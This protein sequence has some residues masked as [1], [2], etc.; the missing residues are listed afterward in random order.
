MRLQAEL[1]NQSRD[2]WSA[3]D[4]WSLGWQLYD[5]ETD[6]FLAEGE[7]RRP[8]A[9][10]PPGSSAT[11]DWELTVP[12]ESG[13]YR[14]YLSAV[15][16]QGGWQYAKGAPFVAADLV[17]ESGQARLIRQRQV[18]LARLRWEKRAALWKR[19]LFG[20]FQLLI[21]HW[22]LVRSMVRRDVS[23]RYRGSFGDALWTF[24][25][26]LLLMAAYYFVFAVVLRARFPG[27]P[28]RSGFFLYF[29][30]GMLPWLA[31]SES[32]GRSPQLMLENRNLVKKILFPVETLPINLTLV[33]LVTQAF[34]TLLFL[35]GLI[36]LRG[37]I[38]ITTLALPLLLVPQLLFTAGLC[39]ALAALGVFF[40][41]L[42]QIIGFLLT[43]WF[44]LTPICYPEASLPP[45]ALHW[46]RWNPIF[47]LVRGYRAVLLESHLP[48]ILNLA[49]LWVTGL[50]AAWLGHGL[51]FKLRRAIPDVL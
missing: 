6:F 24:L 44:F 2:T 18:T 45:D 8:A 40:R 29:F 9:P 3:E 35:A 7:W 48:P 13:P 42:A 38:P 17:V 10:V 11:I 49:I 30:A 33:G 25:N 32:L 41:D 15:S 50:V 26:P 19:L 20:P 47:H 34:A 21:R 1:P 36:L 43:L 51:F 16:E 4:G 14:I 37:S 31:F 39:W 46:L 23:A 27:D 12:P 22:P 5:P 28:T